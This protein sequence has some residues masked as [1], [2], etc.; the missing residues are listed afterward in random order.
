MPQLMYSGLV[1]FAVIL[2][3][4]SVFLLGTRIFHKTE[5]VSLHDEWEETRTNIV[6]SDYKKNFIL[7]IAISFG[8]GYLITGRLIFAVFALAGAAP[9]AK[10]LGNQAMRK[11]KALMEDQ[12][13]QVLNTMI[14][15]LQG[16][17]SNVYK[18]L[19]ETVASLK[20]PARE[21]FIEI[22]R[23]TRTGTKHYEAI[24]AVA[25]ETQWE[26]LKQLEMAFRLYDTTGSNLQQVCTHL[27]KNAYDR[28]GN[29]KYV[30]A[31]TAQIR[32]T[33]MV[34]SAIPFFLITFMRFVAPDFIHP[35]FH[36]MPGITVFIVIILMVL[37]G[38]KLINNMV[39]GIQA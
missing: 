36:T 19:E 15:S 8:I 24:G 27:L 3:G 4:V 10:W 12:Y 31:T 38:N 23:R 16:S 17:S 18:I 33:A 13:T 26:D 1:G 11:R 6:R 39:K 35:L 32:S 30:D 7:G 21:V 20:N 25:E 37:T 9:I 22:L 28:K 29:K 2:I 5:G 14:T 34:L